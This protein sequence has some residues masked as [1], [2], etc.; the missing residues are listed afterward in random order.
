MN[1]Q[2][3]EFNREEFALMLKSLRDG[4]SILAFS[5]IVGIPERTINA[6][7]NKKTTPSIDNLMRLAKHF[8]C[9]IDYLV[10][11]KEY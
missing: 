4:K 2:K 8:D 10:G 9:S 7:T 11:L 6:W 5:K 1:I 3:A